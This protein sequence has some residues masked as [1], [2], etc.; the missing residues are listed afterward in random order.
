MSSDRADNKARRLETYAGHLKR[1]KASAIEAPSQKT[2]SDITGLMMPDDSAKAAP[3]YHSH[4]PSS[5]TG[6]KDMNHTQ[7]SP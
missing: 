3:P 6:A 5:P 2:A 1:N 7:K 4:K